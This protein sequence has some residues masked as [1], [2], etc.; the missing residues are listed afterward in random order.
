VIWAGQSASHE[1]MTETADKADDG[2]Q[3][4]DWNAGDF[5]E[6]YWAGRWRCPATGC[7]KI[8]KVGFLTNMLPD[9]QVTFQLEAPNPSGPPTVVFGPVTQPMTNNTYYEFDVNLAVGPSPSDSTVSQ[10]L[11]LHVT[12]SPSWVSFRE[13]VFLTCN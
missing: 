7:P 11:E 3:C 13:V 8:A 10:G 1:Y 6:Q 4:T 12:A 5:P 2:S 9:G